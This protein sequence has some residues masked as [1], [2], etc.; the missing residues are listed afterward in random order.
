MSVIWRGS[1]TPRH[2]LIT[3]G[4]RGI[5]AE[6]VRAFSAAGDTVAFTYHSSGE[7]ARA[8][9]DE[10]G[11]LCFPC[12]A[13]SE[14]DMNRLKGS[15]LPLFH[16]LDVLISN[17]GTSSTGLME[18]MTVDEWDDLFAVHT[19][20]AF[21]VTRAFLPALRIRGGNILYI[22][23]MWGV[24][25]GSCEAAYSAAKASLIGLT[26]ALSKELAPGIRVNCIAPGVIDTDMMAAYSGADKEALRAATPLGRLGQPRDI[27]SAALFL[28]SD[29]ASFITG[30]TL[31]VD[32]GLTC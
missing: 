26:K 16:T 13:R 27:A 23:S 18:D 32:G 12:D 31:L 10:T 15:L 11:A 21:L 28:C 25:G 1:E 4:S 6:L 9:S 3:G 29:A 5:G 24:S 8:L 30:Q 7:N 14:T 2:V 19:R 20:G 22:S 17:A